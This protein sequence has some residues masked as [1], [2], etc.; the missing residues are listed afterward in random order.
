MNLFSRVANQVS[1]C[2]RAVAY[3]AGVLDEIAPGWEDKVDTAVL[4]LLDVDNCV[5][6]QVFADNSRSEEQCY[7]GCGLYLG[8]VSGYT[9]AMETYE[10]KLDMVQNGVFSHNGEYLGAWVDLI[11]KR[12]KAKAKAV[13]KTDHALVA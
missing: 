13:S 12:Q 6:G 7:C 8:G 2:D 3:A 5:L 1:R 4:D 9:Y 10:T 11:E